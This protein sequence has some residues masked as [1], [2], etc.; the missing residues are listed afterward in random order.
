[1]VLGIYIKNNW[2]TITKRERERERNLKRLVEKGN[3]CIVNSECSKYEGLWTRKLGKDK[4]LYNRLCKYNW[5][6]SKY[7][8]NKENR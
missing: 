6:R 7:N 8:Q 2:E 5:E 1:M 3:L 4:S